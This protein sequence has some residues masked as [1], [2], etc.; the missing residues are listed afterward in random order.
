M[1]RLAGRSGGGTDGGVE[2]GRSVRGEEKEE[3]G[4]GPRGG[5]ALAW[6]AFKGGC[7]SPHMEPCMSAPCSRI[8]TT[9]R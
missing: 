8:I 1:G 9:C 5:Q 7:P 3:L 6:D 4:V 2:E